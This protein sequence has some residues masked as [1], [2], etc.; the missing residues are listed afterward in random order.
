VPRRRRGRRRRRRRSPR[1]RGRRA[2]ACGAPAC[3]RAEPRW[4]DRTRP[5]CSR[6]GYRNGRPGVHSNEGFGDLASPSPLRVI[7]S[8]A[9]ARTL[10]TRRR[11]R[12]EGEFMGTAGTTKG[13]SAAAGDRGGVRRPGSGERIASASGR[14]IVAR[15]RPRAG[16]PVPAVARP[17]PLTLLPGGDFESGDGR[18][19]AVRRRAGRGRQR[20]VRDHR[21]VGL[22]FAAA[23]AGKLGDEPGDVHG[24]L[25]PVVR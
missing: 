23:A 6:S 13:H 4:R 20:A 8:R 2:A 24:L 19:E 16:A 10:R 17:S 11:T 12:G 7:V 22:A 1:V 9:L 15:L 21:H 18:M 3:P 25:L 5:C 14:R